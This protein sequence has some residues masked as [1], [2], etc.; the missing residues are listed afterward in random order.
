MRGALARGIMDV[1]AGIAGAFRIVPRLDPDA[2]MKAAGISPDDDPPLVAQPVEL[3]VAHLLLVI[4][5]D[6][7]DGRFG[8]RPVPEVKLVEG[9]DDQEPLH[10]VEG[11]AGDD[12]VSD[13]ELRA[14]VKVPDSDLTTQAAAGDD[15]AVARV[16]GNAPRSPG[17]S[18][19]GR[20]TLP[21]LDSRHVDVVVPVSAGHQ[22]LVRAEDHEKA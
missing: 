8:L 2:I 14:T 12:S 11:E 20:H 15:I 21:A 4:A 13:P 1:I 17:M 3:H 19:Q 7:L 9:G 10:G 6:D 16:E 5:G 18:S 22:T